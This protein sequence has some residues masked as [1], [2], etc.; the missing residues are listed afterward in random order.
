[1]KKI[2]EIAIFCFIATFGLA[3]CSLEDENKHELYTIAFATVLSP[4]SSYGTY[5]LELDNGLKLF[6]KEIGEASSIFLPEDSSRV[7]ATF[8]LLEDA[9]QNSTYDKN[10]KIINVI[11]IETKKII[12][13]TAENKDSIG[14][15]RFGISLIYPAKDMLNVMYNYSSATTNSPS[16]SLVKNTSKTYDTGTD[17]VHLE[18]LFKNSHMGSTFISHGVGFDLKPLYNNKDSITL[19]IDAFTESET[20][21]TSYS[22]SYKWKKD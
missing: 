11:H 10:I 19:M 1:M 6:T 16:L 8:V 21:P 3:S 18:L 17:T 22:F 5:Y 7:L 9:P 20:T 12:D 2:K 15:N 14:S 4:N 13:L